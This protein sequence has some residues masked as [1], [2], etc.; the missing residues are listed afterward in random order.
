MTDNVQLKI[1][2]VTDLKDNL[3]EQEGKTSDRTLIVY[4]EAYRLAEVTIEDDFL[5]RGKVTTDPAGKWKVTLEELPEGERY[6]QA[7]VDGKRSQSWIVYI[8]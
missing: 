7:E 3:I 4:G 6:F 8:V 5:P 2:K 1:T